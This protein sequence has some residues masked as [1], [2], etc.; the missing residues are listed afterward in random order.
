[1]SFE[2]HYLSP[3]RPTNPAELGFPLMLVYELALAESPVK[4]ICEAWGLTKDALT[5]LIQHPRFVATYDKACED[6]LDPEM[7]IKIKA[8]MVSEEG[9]KTVFT[10]MQNSEVAPAVRLDAVKL[11]NA[12]AGIGQKGSEAAGGGGSH[13]S[14]N[15]DLR[16]GSGEANVRTRL[17]RIIDAE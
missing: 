15:I 1:M 17:P 11:A 4:D 12:M 6:L 3:I 2:A 7:A 14:I 10:I 16:G 9:L 8:M 5:S 13:F